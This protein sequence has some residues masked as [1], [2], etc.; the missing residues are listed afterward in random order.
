MAGVSLADPQRAAGW[1]RRA[2]AGGPQG[3]RRRRRP[4]GSQV[5]S[6]QSVAETRRRSHGEHAIY[7][8]AAKNRYYGAVLLGHD[9]DGRR[10]RSKVSGKSKQQLRDKLDPGHAARD[11][12]DIARQALISIVLA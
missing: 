2:S 6:F 9:A 5:V 3:R 4:A 11:L 1:D 10:I 12:K 8:D 7:F